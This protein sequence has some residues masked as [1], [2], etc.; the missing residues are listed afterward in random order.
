MSKAAFVGFGEVN[1]PK[2]LIVKKCESAFEALKNEGVDVFGVFPVTDDYEEK[3]VNWAIEQL[4]GQDFDYL[5][6]CKDG[7][8]NG[9][10]GGRHDHRH[11]KSRGREKLVDSAK[12]ELKPYRHY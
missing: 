7:Q 3:D 9:G 12:E 11:V 4:S 5:V 6:I 10:K 8:G 2:E 1:T